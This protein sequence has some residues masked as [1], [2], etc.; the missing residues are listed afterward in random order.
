MHHHSA[1]VCS[2]ITGFLPKCSGKITVY[3]SMQNLYQVVKY[4]L[5]NNQNWIH[6]MSDL[7]LH[8]KIVNTTPLTVEDRLLIKT[9]QTEKGSTV[10]K[11]DC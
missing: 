8:L 4:F 6:V 10:E 5:I 1:T 9:L 2:R 7:T 3:Q 11:N